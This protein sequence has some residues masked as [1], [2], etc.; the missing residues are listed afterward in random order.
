VP[1]I[2]DEY[3]T[4]LPGAGLA[5]RPG[6]GHLRLDGADVASFLQAL[7]TNDVSRLERGEGAYATYLTPTGR[8]LTDLEIHRRPEFW[9]LGLEAERAGPIMERLDQSI[10][11]EDVRVTDVTG[12]LVEIVVVGGAAAGCVAAALSMDVERLD[13]LRELGQLEWQNGFVARRGGSRLPMFSVVVGTAERADVTGRLRASGAG[14]VSPELLEALRIDAGRPRFGAD[15]TEETIPLEAGLLD[16]AISTT[17]GCYVGQE[18]IIRVLHRGGGRVAKRLVTL[19]VAPLPG[20]VPPVGTP[21]LD[22]DRAVG[23]LTSVSM[24]LTALNVIALGYLHRDVAEEGRQVRVGDTTARA[25]V[26][27]LAG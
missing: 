4:I 8:M 5:D 6:R 13:A 25:T 22:G 26:T 15:M 14:T 12:Q 19:S 23:Q 24:S 20:G 18:I 17:K 16:R 3:R 1:V 11:S 9:L 2:Q 10:F 27:G 21:L 7:V